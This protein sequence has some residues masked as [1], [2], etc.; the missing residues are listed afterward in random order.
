MTTTVIIPAAGLGTRFNAFIPKQFTLLNGI[1]I[2][3]HTLKLFNN[4]PNIHSIVLAVAKDQLEL[5]QELIETYTI[6]KI[7]D[8]VIGGGER[9][10]SVMSALES[11]TVTK[12]DVILIH[13][14]VRPFASDFLVNSII[15][16]ASE[17]GAVIPIMQPKETI[18]QIRTKN[19]ILHTL[20]R[21]ELCM[22]Q[23][24]QGFRRTV[25]YDAYQYIKSHKI[26]TTDDASVV[27]SSGGTVH[28]I[29]GE[30]N[31][32]K[33]TT[34]LDFK[35]AQLISQTNINTKLI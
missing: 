22:A 5:I 33:I 7:T 4:N 10:H 34:P 1:P 29:K 30:E 27:E 14:A 24:P 15:N 20:N 2:I 21:A 31:N 11:P 16:S 25:I 32:I 13:D 19:I 23:T 8:I 26:L 12:A 18:K 6:T 3:I 9:Q 28:F 17:L 35:L